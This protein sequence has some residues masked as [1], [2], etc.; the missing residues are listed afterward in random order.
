MASS[1]NQQQTFPAVPPSL[2]AGDHEM[3]DY[4][5]PQDAPRPSINQTPYLTPYLGLRARLSQVWINRWTILLLLVLVR[6]L[7]AVSGINDNLS[8]ARQE[9]LR[10]CTEVEN[11]GSTMA[12]M[13][14]YMAQGVNELTASGVE[15]AVNGL[16]SMI[17][18]S[19]TGV[20]NI[21]LFVINMMT[22]TY[23][24]LITLAVSGSLHA[25]VSLGDE[26]VKILN[27]TIPAIGDDI[28][29]VTST[30]EK[31]FNS[32]MNSLKSIPFANINPPTLNLDTDIEKLKNLTMPTD[33]TTGLQ[34]LNNSIPTFA[35]VQNFTQTVIRFPF[36]EVK[37]LISEA[38]GNYTFNRTTLPIPQK[39]QLSFCSDNN[40]INDFFDG[41]V[42]LE[43]MARKIFI[44]VIIVLAILACIPMA[45]REIRRWRKMQQRAQLVGQSGYDSMD[46]VYIASRPYTAT[47]GIK[48]ANYFG[49][50][51]RQTA[52]RWAVA[53]ATSIPALFVLCLGLAGLFS[54]L[55]QYILLKAIEKEVPALTSQVANFA[56]KVV[57]AL[58]NAS[59]TW[60]NG[61]NDAI[62][63]TN[64]DI[65]N[66]MFG[67]VNTTT[68]AV[69][70]TLN[71]FVDQMTGA[72]NTTFGGTILYEPIM[73]VLNCLVLLKL[74]GFQKA[75]TWVSDN[76][77][78]DFPLLAND[79]FSIGAVATISGDSS[80]ASLLANPGGTTSDE[81]SASVLKLTAKLENG[82][83]TEAIIASCLVLIWVFIAL[84][85][86][87]RICTVLL[88]RQK[89]RAEGGQAYVVDPVTDNFRG[90]DF[91]PDTAAPP[92]EYPVNKA[93]PYT[94][95]P[96]PFPT[97]E[98]TANAYSSE[99]EKVGQVGAHNVGD[100]VARPGH[101]R[102]SSHGDLGGTTPY[103]EKSANNPFAE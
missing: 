1:E 2:S 95:Q 89:T 94:I 68:T 102:A 16:M 43:I 82:I 22:Q 20:E 35:E 67:W 29:S 93:A 57:N 3:R 40:G 38:M 97:F 58:N 52:V 69:N 88:W 78:V 48:V 74:Q 70:S 5:A 4:Y 45:Y 25:A 17:N 73:G 101:V 79:T 32:F 56:D 77:H 11:V 71:E 42:K 65:N 55:C 99:D 27:S 96:R 85:G 64:A 10:A 92:Y 63:T 50:T 19:V 37:K 26:V 54:C 34:D 49:S 24:C 60:A 15:K 100:S 46:V 53:Y 86:L 62:N 103:N 7:I 8:S 87:I 41:L 61:V 84:I 12:S 72:L 36:E 66:N 90:H 51:R 75:L 83:R 18:L 31:D 98:P 21:V 80:S 47:F 91:R 23:V 14:H 44:A 76:A 30:F 33:I 81:I 59:E 6:T 39:E 28:A 13:P 9:A